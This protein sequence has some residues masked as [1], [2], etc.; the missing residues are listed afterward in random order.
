[1]RPDPILDPAGVDLDACLA[2]GDALLRVNP[3]RFEMIQLDKVIAIDDEAKAIVGLK[4]VRDDEFWVRGHFPDYAVMPGVLMCEAAAQLSGYYLI[5]RKVMGED[6]LVGFGG[7]EGV[8]FRAAVK[9]GDRVLLMAKAT[10]LHRRQAVFHCQAF[11]SSTGSFADGRSQMAFHGDIL[12]L[13]L[14]FETNFRSAG[15]SPE[16]VAS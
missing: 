7:M 10:K 11:V 12:G 9:P 5:T 1:M 6:Q 8:K 16:E 14:K 15:T 2:D 4:D 13:P 3:H